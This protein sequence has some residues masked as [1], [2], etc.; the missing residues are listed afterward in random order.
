MW[1]FTF[2]CAYMYTCVAS[3]GISVYI[4]HAGADVIILMFDITN[5]ESFDDLNTLWMKRIRESVYPQV[6]PSDK[7][8]IVVGN[9]ADLEVQR[10]VE[11]AETREFSAEIEATCC[12]ETSAKSGL[13]TKELL[14]LCTLP[15]LETKT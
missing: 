1:D 5:K 7:T 8:L 9:K 2:L 15:T 12:M 4:L 6:I 10:S 11:V 14:D 13:N 3:S